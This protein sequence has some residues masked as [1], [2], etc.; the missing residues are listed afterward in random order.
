MEK[1]GKASGAD[2][3][4][5]HFV[6]SE[7]PGEAVNPAQIARF[8]AA[9]A[10]F[11][12]LKASLANSSGMFLPVRPIYDLARPGYALYGGNPTPG[13]PI[14]CARSR[15]SPSRS[16]SRDGSRRG[17]LAAITGSG[18]PNGERGSQ[19][20]SPAMRMACRAAQAPQIRRPGAKW[21]AG[22]RCPLVGR[23]SMDLCVVDVTDLPEDAVRPGDLVEFFGS[24]C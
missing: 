22:R 19:P 20:C 11:P 7:I 14:R 10:A 6:S 4:M 24:I 9:R 13:G 16:S 17:K 3:L 23:V 8:E 2:L 15:R 5:S 18:P 12:S 1:H 21:V